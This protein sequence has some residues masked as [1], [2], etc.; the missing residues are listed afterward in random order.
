M[1][2]LF[3]TM[4]REVVEF[5]G[6]RNQAFLVVVS[7]LV[8]CAALSKFLA[9]E[10]SNGPD[11]H[12]TFAQ[13]F[14]NAEA[15]VHDVVADYCKQIKT[16]IESCREENETPPEHP[17]VAVHDPRIAPARR[18]RM[19]C[20]HARNMM[21][22]LRTSKVVFSWLPSSIS[23]GLAYAQLM[24]EWMAT[25]EADI[26]YRSMRFVIREDKDQPHLSSLVAAGNS[27][28]IRIYKPDLGPAAIEKSLEDEVNDESAPLPK[29]MNFL[30]ILAGMD[31]GFNRPVAAVEKFGLLARYYCGTQDK[32][33][34]ALSLN[35]VGEA[36]A[37]A[38][39][40]QKA[41]HHFE[42]ALTPAAQINHGQALITIATNLANLHF[43]HQQWVPA[44]EHYGALGDLAT[45]TRNPKLKL[46]T[47]EYRGICAQNFG[48][49]DLALESWKA[50]VDLADGIDD[51]PE[52]RAFYR[53]I[54][55]V[56]DQAGLT[57]ESLV[58][59]AKMAALDQR[60]KEASAT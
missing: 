49:L 2:K 12:W 54:R 21:S 48:R 5:L 47:H 26:W 57:Q 20:E 34:E 7:G 45:A 32:A 42:T 50:G 35:G 55:Q 40:Y 37:R 4:Q 22:D 53:R 6:Q 43:A 41:K 28:R 39:N 19:I 13:P 18:L 59:Q 33:M 23:D 1:Q 31:I 14:T 52:T 16:L 51:F 10:E 3:D 17:P 30:F 24:I 38:G 58:V 25:H 46:I 56:Y 15:W 11:V 36:Y 60:E 8:E 9:D 29:R 27:P 44:Y